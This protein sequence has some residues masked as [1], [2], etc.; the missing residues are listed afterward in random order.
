MDCPAGV[1]IP[2]VFAIY[3]HYRNVRLSSETMAD[4]VFRNT[5][6]RVLN[7]S[8]KAHN[9]VSCEKCVRHCPQG[10]EI[11]KFMEDIAAFAAA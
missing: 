10:I 9:C 1:D 3:N 8:Q 11:P 6:T 4:I 7:E 5:Y 2:R